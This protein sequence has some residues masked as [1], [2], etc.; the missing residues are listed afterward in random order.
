MMVAPTPEMAG[1]TDSTGKA[2][3]NLFGV[4]ETLAYIDSSVAL[5]RQVLPSV[6]VI[7]TVFNQAE[8]QSMAAL[9][10][11]KDQCNRAGMKLISLPVNNSSETQLVVNSLLSKNI[12]VFLRC[13]TT[14]SLHLL[15]RLPKF[16]MIKTF[17]FLLQRQDW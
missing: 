2:P 10:V 1:L 6:K 16:V 13:P 3:D 17:P 7:G 14:P 12:E 8:P 5:I 4:Y 11:I 15:K 9:S